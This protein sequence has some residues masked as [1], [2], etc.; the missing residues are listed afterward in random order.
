MKRQFDIYLYSSFFATQCHL[1]KIRDLICKENGLKS[2]GE[3]A[4]NI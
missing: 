4:I 3:I 2:K 1:L